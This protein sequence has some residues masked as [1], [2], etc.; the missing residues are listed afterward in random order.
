MFRRGGLGE[1]QRGGD[2]QKEGGFEGHDRKQGTAE[3][4]TEVILV[5]PVSCSDCDRDEN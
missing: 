2:D 3:V 4:T 1:E 5:L